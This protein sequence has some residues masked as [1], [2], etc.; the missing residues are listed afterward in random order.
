MR[1]VHRCVKHV[2]ITLKNK[3]MRTPTFVRS[4]LYEIYEE[5]FNVIARHRSFKHS[6]K[7]HQSKVAQIYR[8]CGVNIVYGFL[9]CIFWRLRGDNIVFVCVPSMM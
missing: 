6:S 7:S 9:S 3:K 4:V 5:S 1:L 2:R 8:L